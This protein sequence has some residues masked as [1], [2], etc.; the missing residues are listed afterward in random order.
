MIRSAVALVLFGGLAALPAPAQEARPEALW[1]QFRGPNASGVAPDG[2]TLPERFGPT[3]HV[4]WKTPLPAGHSS[5]C[6]WG[7]HIFLTGYDVD[8]KRLET[9]ALDRST[10]QI[11]WRRPAPAVAIEKVHQI[12]TP[13]VSTP[14]TDGERVYVYFGSFGLL[15]YDVAGAELWKVPLPVPQTRFGSGTSPV[16]AGDL[17]ILHGEYPPKPFLLAVDRRTGATAWRKDLSLPM[18]E[19]YATPALWSHDGTDELV[20]HRPG[21]VVGHDPKDGT[22]RWWVGVNSTAC[23]SPVVGDGQL[24]ALTWMMGADPTD[25]VKLPTFDELL[26][27]YDTNKDGKISKDE[28]PADLSVFKRSEAGDI[29]GADMKVKPFFSQLDMNKDGHI[30]RLE[31]GMVQLFVNRPVEHGLFAVKP[32]GQGDVTRSHVLWRDAKGTPEVPSPLYYRGRVYLVRDGGLASCLDAATGKLLYRERLGPGGAYFASPV[33]GDGKL[34]A[35]SR[36]GEV[37]VFAAG[38]TFQVL[39]RNDLHESIMATPALA[40]GKVYVRTEGHLYAFEK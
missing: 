11:R 1:P 19:G 23:S 27:K 7:N 17:L 37:V 20:L 38:D 6:V 9:L 15:C 34:Y 40:G 24:F 10:G 25:R 5:P 8:Q 2:M 26:A 36:G 35:A 31:W 4:A 21:R 14:V 33:A 28:F 18:M 29:P 39:A 16:L 3:D 13:A 22:E 12:S 30:D 32:G